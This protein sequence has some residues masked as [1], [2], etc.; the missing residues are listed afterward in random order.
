MRNGYPVKHGAL[1]RNIH[2]QETQMEKYDV[3]IIGAG[4]S[5]AACARE[6]SKYQLKTLVLEASEDVCTG[7]SKANSG[8]VHAGYDAR[9]GSL[10]AKLNVEGNAMMGELAK[11]L[12][13]PFKRNG[14]L[15]VCIDE[16]SRD[17]LDELLER[18]RRNGV[19]DLRII[20]REEL[21]EMEPN[22]SDEA[23]A[24]LY[25][26]TAGIICP[27]LLT[28]AM[29]ENAA[30]NGVEFRFNSPVDTIEKAE[31]GFKVTACADD[32]TT[33]YFT[34]VVIN[35]AGV[36]SDRFHNIFAKE[37]ITIIPRR[38]DY[39]LM[40]KEAGG[41]V[42]RTIFPLPGPMGKGILVAP[43]VHG[44]LYAGPTSIDIE[45][46]EDHATRQDGLSKVIADCGRYVKNVPLRSAITS[47]SGNRA[48][49]EGHEFIIGELAEAPGFIDCAAIES[50]G[51]TSSPA[52][53]KM[54][55]GIVYGILSPEEKKT[56]KKTRKGILDP[57]TLS[58]EERN[59]LIKEQPAYGRVVCRCEG[60]TEGEILDAIHRPLGA[61][62][63]DGLKRRVRAGAGRCQAGF[64]TPRQMEIL[65]REL[66]I[67]MEEVTK[68]GKGSYIVK[69]RAKDEL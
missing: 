12:D 49:W 22:I 3:I 33:Q 59:R 43:T 46:K 66:G 30:E 26:P 57:N 54:V 28:I 56:W 10:M 7:T 40:D 29:A 32:G 60:I 58:L 68:R 35:A 44:N 15:V 1:L 62:T 65:S 41:L 14:S 31:G 53:G 48:H 16:G 39:I 11:D 17:K 50:P 42:Q 19:P 55:S 18:G 23:V 20:E 38:G 9:E 51:L 2:I 21:K 67:S 47:F 4:V 34:K 36:Y 37:K 25:A 45:S 27:F 61:S 13:I 5:G 24:A 8:I 64:C 52:I 63:M 69:G 6:L